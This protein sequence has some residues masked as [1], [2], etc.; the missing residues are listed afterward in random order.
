MSIRNDKCDWE[1][2]VKIALYNDE[3]TEYSRRKLIKYAI[4]Y[5]NGEFNKQLDFRLKWIRFIGGK[6]NIELRRELE[7]KVSA[8]ITSYYSQYSKSN[9]S[10]YVKFA[11]YIRN[12]TNPEIISRTNSI[13]YI[14]KKCL[15]NEQLIN[16]FEEYYPDLNTYRKN[17]LNRKI[18][19][20]LWI[21]YILD[22]NGAQY[23]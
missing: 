17:K 21:D 2:N 20:K 13:S 15:N 7:W 5:S 18:R 11:E 14:A 3:L 8:L 19:D 22:E 12:Q 16:L 9:Y 1:K 10:K 23:G 4:D 6:N